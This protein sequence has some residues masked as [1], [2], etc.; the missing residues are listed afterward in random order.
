MARRPRAS[1]ASR[2][3][4]DDHCRTESEGLSRGG[5]GGLSADDVQRLRGIIPATP[6]G[7]R[8]RAIILTSL[9][10]GRRRSEVLNLTAADIEPGGGPA[11]YRYRKGGK[12]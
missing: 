9:L 1:R 3:A 2:S 4:S 10:T 5:T 8:D 11:F 12:Q 6:V 7:L